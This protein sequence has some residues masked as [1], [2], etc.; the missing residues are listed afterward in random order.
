MANATITVAN[1]T[2][3]MQDANGGDTYDA[4]KAIFTHLPTKY[5]FVITDAVKHTL[6]THPDW[7]CDLST[8]GKINGGQAYADMDK[9]MREANSAY[10]VDINELPML[11]ML[12]INYMKLM[13]ADL[14]SPNAWVVSALR[15]RWTQLGALRTALAG[16]GNLEAE[17]T[18]LK[19]DHS[20]C[21][22]ET[23][24]IA[25]AKT[26]DDVIAALGA[27]AVNFIS[28]YHNVDHGYKWVVKHAENIWAA[29]ECV[30]KLRGHHMKTG[31][32]EEKAFCDL[33]TRILTAAYEGNFTFP[34]RI[35]MEHL[36]RTSTHCFLIQ[37]LPVMTSKFIAYNKVGASTVMRLSSGPC[38]C[39]QVTTAAAALDTMSGE[40][41]F[42][43]FKTMY[44]TQVNAAIEAKN[45]ILNDKYSYH[46]AA[47][48]YGC[49]KKT[50]VTIAGKKMQLSDV[51]SLIQN[52]AAACQGLINALMSAQE[53]D[54]ITG[55]ALKNAMALQKAAS[56]APLMSLRVKAIVEASIDEIADA[57]TAIAAI[58]AA[59]PTLNLKEEAKAVK[60]DN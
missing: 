33:Y 21:S 46:I 7:A 34:A 38:G 28:E 39:A 22:A 18:V 4:N 24:Q 49:V 36:F 43:K 54:L 5:H 11:K 41:W 53:A 50:E 37:A 17:H 32:K 6:Q 29:V 16:V 27:S 13:R 14:D 12:A 55:F 1:L 52:V 9:A 2:A 58:H 48:L 19:T 59:F 47:G 26:L 23:K 20:G 3:F 40:V 44:A 56:A 30:F 25:S 35:K 45:A 10:K 60:A 15:C 42:E 57:N 8:F 51:I 31:G